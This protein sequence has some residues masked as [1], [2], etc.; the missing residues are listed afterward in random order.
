[1]NLRRLAETDGTSKQTVFPCGRDDG[2]VHEGNAERRNE[3][4]ARS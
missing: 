3:K 4:E 1:L 2:S